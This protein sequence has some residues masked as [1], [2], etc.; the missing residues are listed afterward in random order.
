VRK[1]SGREYTAYR[2]PRDPDGQCPAPPPPAQAD[3]NPARQAGQAG[4]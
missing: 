2:L 3:S 4:G 1:D